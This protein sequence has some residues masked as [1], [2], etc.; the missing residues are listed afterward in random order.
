[1]SGK[2]I[3]RDK[4]CRGGGRGPR[5]VRGGSEGGETVWRH[6]PSSPDGFLITIMHWKTIIMSTVQC[7]VS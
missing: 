5:V 7:T 1:M 3:K 6:Q 2:P 4:A